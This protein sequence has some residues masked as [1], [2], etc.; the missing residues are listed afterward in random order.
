ME[1]ARLQLGHQLRHRRPIAAIGIEQRPLEIRRHLDIHRRADRGAHPIGHIA[2]RPHGTIKDVVLVGRDHQLLD[3][4]PHLARDIARE[5]VAEIAR[6]HGKADGTMRRAQR[7]G[8]R[9]IIDDLRQNPRPVDGIHP[10]QPHAI[11]EGEIVEHVLH[12]R[13]GII[14]IAVDGQRVD[15]GFNRRRHLASLHLGYPAM[16]V[17]DEQIDIRQSPERL[18]RRRSGIARGGPHDGDPLPR[19]GQRRLHHLPDELHGE[20]LE[21]QRGPVEQLQQEMVRA[22]LHQ[23]R[24]GVM[25]E[26]RIGPGDQAA[27]FVIAK[28]VAQ[29]GAHH[30]EGDLLI[31]QPRH[32]GDG[33]LRQ[34]RHGLRHIKPAIPGQ[35]RH[36]RF[37]E[38]QNRCSTTGRDIV[39]SHAFMPFAA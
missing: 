22:K 35:P 37:A 21:G 5:D 15:I 18:H 12:A 6:R 3:R 14:E 23:R 17:K 25:A 2:P 33:L 19:L 8:G 32:R 4:Q 29:K 10:R 9:E 16:R 36:H 26:T 20:I 28:G 30:A 7:Q 31:G 38:C 1:P 11:A 24:A 27:E 39:H 13:L 34:G